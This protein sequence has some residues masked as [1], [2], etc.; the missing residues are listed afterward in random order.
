MFMFKIKKHF[1]V[2]VAIVGYIV[3]LG[4][5]KSAIAQTIVEDSGDGIVTPSSVDL[6]DSYY[7][8]K[9]T[10]ITEEGEKEV[11]PGLWQ[12]YQIIELEIINGDEKGKKILIDHGGSFAITE[13]QKVRTGEYLVIAKTPDLPG[14]RSV[15]YVI[16]K[17][18]INGLALVIAI[19][20]ATAI[21]FGRKRGVSA[22]I[23]LF[24]TVL[25]IFYYI[26]PQI[27][28]GGNP[29]LICIAGAIP[30][31]LVSLYI[32]HGF[33][34]RTSIAVISGF[35]VL[36]LAVV[37]DLVFVYVTKLA[38]NG[39][40]EAFYLQFG[41]VN[42][43][44][45]GVLLGGIIIGVLGVLDDITTAQSAAI[46]EISK[47]DQS[48]SFSELYFRGMSIGREHIASL[49]NTLVLAYVGV[50][51]PFLLLYASQKT[52]ALWMTFNSS[53]VAEEI[54]RTL[55]GSTALVLAVPITTVIAAWVY[56][57]KKG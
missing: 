32:S 19:F 44:L 57:K 8:A 56:G 35:I 45:R 28:Q 11:E 12:M 25:A 4:T 39:T 14:S 49:I 51:F 40:E 15:Y 53:F 27:L 31:L 47:A 5:S 50:S 9:V 30:I 46:E 2:F 26:I 16:D 3:F 42:L 21:Y 52:Q 33:S 7:R 6:S 34:R 13:G 48:L 43:N 41:A 54:V 10:A 38:G 24:F 17:Y 22:I 1:F 29:L 18:R 20:F 23:G 55:V 37:I 36:G